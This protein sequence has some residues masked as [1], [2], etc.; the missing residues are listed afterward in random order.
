MK[1]YSKNIFG[2]TVA[3]IALGLAVITILS[4]AYIFTLQLSWKNARTQLAPQIAMADEEYPEISM[5]DRRTVGDYLF[6]NYL[7]SYISRSGSSTAINFKQIPEA[8]NSLKIYFKDTT[9]TLTPY[10]EEGRYINVSWKLDGKKYHYTIK[11]IQKYKNIENV[12]DMA[13]ERENERRS[14]Q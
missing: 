6:M 1:K 14:E 3:G 2:K 9:V 13:E 5:G 7:K 11:G 12:F 8:E 10:D 4:L